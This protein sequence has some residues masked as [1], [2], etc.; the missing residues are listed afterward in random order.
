MIFMAGL[1]ELVASWLLGEVELSPE[2]LVT[3]AS[4]SL[5]ALMRRTS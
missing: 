2:D 1:S 3:T 4:D 5:V